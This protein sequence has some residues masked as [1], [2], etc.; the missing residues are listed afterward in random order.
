MMFVVAPDIDTE[1]FVRWTALSFFAS[2][3][4]PTFDLRRARYL[5]PVTI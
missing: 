4:A 5:R 1:K 2:K 3:P